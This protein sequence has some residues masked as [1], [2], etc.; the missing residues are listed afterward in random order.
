MELARHKEL[1]NR[2]SYVR[3]LHAIRCYNTAADALAT[4]KLDAKKKKL[5]LGEERYKE[6]RKLNRIKEKLVGGDKPVE[7]R[8]GM[9]AVSVITRSTTRRVRFAD[10]PSNGRPTARIEESGENQEYEKN[11]QHTVTRSIPETRASSIAEDIDPVIVQ[12]ERRERISTAQEEMTKW[13]DLMVYRRGEFDKLTHPQASD[14][15]K[16]ADRFVLSQDGILYYVNGAENEERRR[17]PTSNC[18][19]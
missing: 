5:P 1:V 17:K 18:N 11:V 6:L 4:E 15:G 13:A 3:Y 7:A 16:I 2:F 8:E 19:L 9:P 10:Q 14:A 12:I